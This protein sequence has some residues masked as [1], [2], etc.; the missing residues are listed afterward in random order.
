MLTVGDE[1]SPVVCA[2]WNDPWLVKHSLPEATHRSKFPTGPLPLSILGHGLIFLCV[3]ILV[4]TLH[5]S[6]A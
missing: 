1:T 3:L 6:V 2:F 4:G 5:A